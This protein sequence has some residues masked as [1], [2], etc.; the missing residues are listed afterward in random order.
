MNGERLLGGVKS[1]PK[2]GRILED[3]YVT[4]ITCKIVMA[5]L[6]ISDFLRTMI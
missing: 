5:E 2:T 6:W 3:L 4:L 1:I